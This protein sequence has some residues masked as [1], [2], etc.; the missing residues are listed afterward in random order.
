MQFTFLVN[1]LQSP[2]LDLILPRIFR[3]EKPIAPTATSYRVRNEEAVMVYECNL[4]ANRAT[5]RGQLVV[6]LN[7]LFFVHPSG[8]VLCK[9]NAVDRVHSHDV[10]RGSNM[11]VEV[12]VEIFDGSRWLLYGFYDSA[13]AFTFLKAFH[14]VQKRTWGDAK[15]FRIPTILFGCCLSKCL[16]SCLDQFEFVKEIPVPWKDEAPP[17]IPRAQVQLLPPE[18]YT[19]DQWVDKVAS[20]SPNTRKIFAN[21]FDP[22]D[23]GS[24]LENTP[25][26]PAPT[27]TDT[28]FQTITHHEKLKAHLNAPMDADTPTTVASQLHVNFGSDTTSETAGSVNSDDR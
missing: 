1:K 26:I 8:S 23:G 18:P 6:T 15:P 3:A 21:Y 17:E 7:Y 11:E 9:W 20:H 2:Y 19:G 5:H 25:N 27:P 22:P 14:S 28:N 13:A 16:D 4:S 10:G 24:N 12:E